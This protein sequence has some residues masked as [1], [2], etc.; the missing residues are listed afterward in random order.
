MIRPL[1]IPVAG[2]TLQA[3]EAGAGPT[4]LLLHGAAADGRLWAPHQAL[5][6]DRWR[7]V[8]P[9]LRYFGTQPWPADGQPRFG[10]DTHA[11]D[12]ISAIEALGGGPVHLVAWSYAGHVALTAAAR[13]PERVASVFA[14]EPGVPVYVTDPAELGVWQA[15]AEAMFGPVIDALEAGDTAAALRA[16]M[17]AAGQ[18]AGVLESLPPEQRTMLED[19]AR[20]LRLQ[21]DQAPPPPLA[22]ADLAALPMPVQVVW[23]GASRPVFRT[24]SQAVARAIAHRTHTEVTG[25]G[26]LWPMQEPAAFTAALRAF[27]ATV[28]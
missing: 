3:T 13:R 24:V 19:N 10:V 26:H 20:T 16:L 2:G 7:A 21:M 6:A 14:Y 8:A 15:D 12:L 4:V 25:A 27:L 1:Q 22:P 17:D 28:S 9:T 11:R 5:L 23:G 18:R